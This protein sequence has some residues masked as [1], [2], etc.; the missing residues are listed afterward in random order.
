MAARVHKRVGS[1]FRYSLHG[2]NMAFVDPI[3]S[4]ITWEDILQTNPLPAASILLP[5]R[6]PSCK[7]RHFAGTPGGR[8]SP[9]QETHNGQRRDDRGR[10]TRASR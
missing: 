4:Q 6:A 8:R 10:D 9:I 1:I 2:A 5:R 3:S 7:R